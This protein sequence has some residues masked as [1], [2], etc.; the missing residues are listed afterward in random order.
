MAGLVS[1]EHCRLVGDLIITWSSIEHVLV[2]TL[3]T[4]MG[5]LSP[6]V[7]PM[8]YSVESSSARI[9]AL[10]KGLTF[11]AERRGWDITELEAIFKEAVGMLRVRNKYAHGVFVGTDE[12]PELV[13]YRESFPG[14]HTPVPL[15]DLQFQVDRARALEQRVMFY[16]VKNNLQ[17]P[18]PPLSEAEDAMQEAKR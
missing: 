17:I 14:S 16:L 2:T 15:Y 3:Y 9:S 1:D 7:H 13:D 8:L 12:G 4:T 11:T 5:D 6:M 10:R 18:P